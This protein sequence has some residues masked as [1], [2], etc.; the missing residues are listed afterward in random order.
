MLDRDA[1]EKALIIN[2]IKEQKWET[3]IEFGIDERYFTGENKE[4]YLYAKKLINDGTYPSIKLMQMQYDIDDDDMSHY[5]QLDSIPELIE[6]LKTDYFDKFQMY[7]LNEFN[8]LLSKGIGSDRN[9][10]ISE[11]GKMYEEIKATGY[12]HKSI[13]LLSNMEEVLT[14]DPNNVISTGFE[15][16]DEVLVGLRRGEE[17]VVIGGRPRRRKKLDRN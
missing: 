5:I 4:I 8:E 17:L 11:M 7:K 13:D 1:I 12:E 2:S 10:Y 6:L 14:V 9:R 16:L 3:L 15:E